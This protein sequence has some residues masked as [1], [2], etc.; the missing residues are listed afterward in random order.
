MDEATKLY[1]ECAYLLDKIFEKCESMEGKW[2]EL[3]DLLAEVDDTQFESERDL[4]YYWYKF[5][6]NVYWRIYP[7]DEKQAFNRVTD[8][9]VYMTKDGK[10]TTVEGYCIWNYDHKLFKWVVNRKLLG[11]TST[12]EIQVPK[13]LLTEAE[14]YRFNNMAKQSK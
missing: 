3:I 12:R 7:W 10:T 1:G 14:K 9:E 5:L 2:D 4:Y 13:E 6:R 11:Y 8:R